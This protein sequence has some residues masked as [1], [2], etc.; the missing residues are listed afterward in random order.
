MDFTSY[1]TFDFYLSFFFLIDLPSICVRFTFGHIRALQ[2]AV[3]DTEGLSDRCDLPR[4]SHFLLL[5]PLF[6]PNL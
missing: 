5:C 1:A 2:Q 4:L 6:S 3:L